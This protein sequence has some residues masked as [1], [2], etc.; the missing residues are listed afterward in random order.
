VTTRPRVIDQT[1]TAGSQWDETVPATT[2]IDA[3]AVR[4]YPAD[5]G[6]GRFEWPFA[7]VD[8]EFETYIVERITVDFGDAASA[9][10]AIVGPAGFRVVLST[11]L[12]NVTIYGPIVMAWDEVVTLQSVGASVQMRARVV[13]G[14]AKLRPPT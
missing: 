14:P 8:R 10:V 9:A 7:A 5:T 12:G 1:I 11:G 4:T 2:P 13:A 3:L 6:G